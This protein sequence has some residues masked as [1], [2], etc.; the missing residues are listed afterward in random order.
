MDWQYCPVE[1]YCHLFLTNWLFQM[2]SEHIGLKCLIQSQDNRST[3]HNNSAGKINLLF[4]A[5]QIRF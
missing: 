1:Q 3:S 4:K 2:L 5:G